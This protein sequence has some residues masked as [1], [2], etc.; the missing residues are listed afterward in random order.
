MPAAPEARTVPSEANEGTQGQLLPKKETSTSEGFH[1]TVAA[2]FSYWGV[3]VRVRVPL[4][5]THAS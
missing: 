2:L 1:S 3:L 5:A 4:F